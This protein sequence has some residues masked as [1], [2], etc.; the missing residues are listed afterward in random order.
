MWD[1]IATNTA[2]LS[3]V[4]TVLPIAFAVIQFILAKRSEAKRLRFETYHSLIKQLVER[5]NPDQPMRLDRQVAVVF[6]LRN[7]PH[8]YPV[9]L[10]LLQGLRVSWSDYGPEDKRERLLTEIDLAI[11]HISAKRRWSIWPQ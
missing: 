6:E 9:T 2:Q 5:E 10:R 1:W 3:V 11:E 8:Y 4:V 7:F